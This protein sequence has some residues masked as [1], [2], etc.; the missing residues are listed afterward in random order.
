MDGEPFQF[1]SEGMT[2]EVF[3]AGDDDPA[4]AERPLPKPRWLIAPFISDGSAM[5]SYYI[6]NLLAEAEVKDVRIEDPMS[7]V[8]F[9]DAAAWETVPSDGVGCQFRASYG[10]GYGIIHQLEV[11]WTDGRN[12]RHADLVQLNPSTDDD[13][14]P[15]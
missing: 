7:Q 9:H 15:F 10:Y 14:V 2:H 5:K 8:V 11:H 12:D 1:W 6:Q 3:P 4:E 13:Y